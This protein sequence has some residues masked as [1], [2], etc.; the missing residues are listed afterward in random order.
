MV[1][2]WGTPLNESSKFQPSLSE[3][4]SSATTHFCKEISQSAQ[5]IWGVR[6]FLLCQKFIIWQCQKSNVNKLEV[7][8]MYIIYMYLHVDYF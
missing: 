1:D 2:S 3:P 6:V 4:K 5:I 7:G 8:Y